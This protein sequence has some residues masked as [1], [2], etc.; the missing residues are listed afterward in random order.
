[1]SQATSGRPVI[2]TVLVSALLAALVGAVVGAVLS[3]A[4]GDSEPEGV[5]GAAER[6]LIER[7]YEESWNNGD[8]SL[9]DELF[10]TDYVLHMQDGR[11]IGRTG[12]RSKFRNFAARFR[13]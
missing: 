9:I 4:L 13:T 1:M 8:I 6:A 3:V 2:Y 11:T 5:A 10:T 12:S 7:F